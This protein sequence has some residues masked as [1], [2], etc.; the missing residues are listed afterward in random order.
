ML[1]VLSA[2]PA[3]GPA[4]AASRADNPLR[5]SAQTQSPPRARPLPSP[6]SRRSPPRAHA[7]PVA[8]QAPS[9]DKGAPSPE[10]R[11]LPTS[12]YRHSRL[13]A[14]GP[15]RSPPELQPPP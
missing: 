2:L 5:Q 6:Q 12:P 3:S 9:S 13:I 15:D 1:R 4:H 7:L 8:A 10:S 14:F 11:T